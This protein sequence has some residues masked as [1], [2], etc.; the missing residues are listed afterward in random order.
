[1]SWPVEKV[2]EEAFKLDPKDRALAG[3]AIGSLRRLGLGRGVSA[4][5]GDKSQEDI[6]EM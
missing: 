2:L 3:D 4:P 5:F 6:G 1:V